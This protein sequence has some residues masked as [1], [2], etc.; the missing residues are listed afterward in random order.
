MQSAKAT[1]FSPD[2]I[3]QGPV[4]E[5][6][7]HLELE[8]GR[9]GYVRAYEVVH[10]ATDVDPMQTAAECIPPRQSAHLLGRARPC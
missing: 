8:D 7:Y 4:G 3:E 6:Y 10:L 5:P 1:S 2:S 9:T